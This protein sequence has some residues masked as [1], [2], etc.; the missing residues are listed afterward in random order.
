M[1][2][3]FVLFLFGLVHSAP[4]YI[5]G[6][7]GRSCMEA[8]YA[9]GMNCNAA[10]STGNTPAIFQSLGVKCSNLNNKPWWA[11]DQPSFEPST[12]TCL[13]YIDVPDAVACQ[14]S[15]PTTQ[16]VCACDKPS[17]A[18]TTFGTGYS[19]GFLNTEERT[20]FAHQNAA[21]NTGVMNHF[22]ITPASAAVMV[23]YYIDGEKEASIQYQPALACGVGFNDDSAPWGTKWFGKGAKTGGWYWNFR[24]PF[25]TSIRITVHSNQTEGTYII[26]RG[27]TN[28][29]INIGGIPLPSTAKLLQFRTDGLYQP[30]EFI[31]LVDIPSGK[32]LFFMHTLAVTS[33]NENFLEA[34]YHQFSPYSQS[35][36]GTVLSTGTEDFF[37]SAFYFDAGEFHLPVSGFTHYST[38]KN[39]TWSAYRFHEEDPITFLDGY[40][41]VWRIGDAYDRSG[42]KCLIKSGGTVVGKPSPSYVKA[43][44]WAY[45]W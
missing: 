4:T 18:V 10:V 15:F 34:C 24:V 35:W 19:Q 28:T 26:F 44:A 40:K 6:G 9:V 16:R 11:S 14:G 31:N 1:H 12:G 33:L 25:Q 23:K 7:V 21:G 5:L 38:A 3:F 22:W 45:I 37:D 20:M 17:S 43:Y 13:G 32:G 30:L 27:A 36:P 42:I 39:V 2:V 29:P 8:C 41:L